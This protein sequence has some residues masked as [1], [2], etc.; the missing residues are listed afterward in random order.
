MLKT[1]DELPLAV[2]S[3]QGAEACGK[4]ENAYRELCRKGAIPAKKIGRH[5]IISRDKLQ[6]FL[7]GENDAD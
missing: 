5:W 1:F 7:N 2:G 4:S 6:A 3:K